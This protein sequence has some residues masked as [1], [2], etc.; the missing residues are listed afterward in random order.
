MKDWTF[1]T[2][3]SGYASGSE[4]LTLCTTVYLKQDVAQF[5]IGLQILQTPYSWIYGEKETAYLF[6]YLFIIDVVHTVHIV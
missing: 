4:K 2:P 1:W 6:I 3:P 5:G